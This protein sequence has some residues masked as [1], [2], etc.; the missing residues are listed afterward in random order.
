MVLKLVE[1]QAND[2]YL[3]SFDDKLTFYLLLLVWVLYQKLLIYILQNATLNRD[4]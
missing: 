4:L 1:I 2:S 3:S